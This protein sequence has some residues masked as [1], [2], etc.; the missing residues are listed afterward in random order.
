VLYLVGGRWAIGTPDDVMTSERL[1]ALYG[2][3]VDVVRVRGRIVV[4]GAPDAAHGDIGAG[5]HHHPVDDEHDEHSAGRP[6]V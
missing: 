3:D 4:V 5:H 2:T 1:S 6:W